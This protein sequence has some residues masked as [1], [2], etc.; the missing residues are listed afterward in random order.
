MPNLELKVK[1]DIHIIEHQQ[2]TTIYCQPH[3]FALT[4]KSFRR[5]KYSDTYMTAK[6]PMSSV[7]AKHV[8]F[9]TVS[10][11]DIYSGKRSDSQYLT[12][13]NSR[14]TTEILYSPQSNMWKPMNKKLE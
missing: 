9:P 6:I 14:A 2:K 8:I 7:A 5:V 10:A 1:E 3:I 4:A 12:P 13:Q 11:E